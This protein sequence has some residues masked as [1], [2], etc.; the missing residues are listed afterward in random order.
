MASH[1]HYCY[2]WM[3]VKKAVNLK[4][5][6]EGVDTGKLSLY[7]FGAYK[8]LK[9]YGRASLRRPRKKHVNSNLYKALLAY[10]YTPEL[11]VTGVAPHNAGFDIVATENSSAT[12]TN[13]RQ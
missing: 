2:E 12:A 3:L 5:M 9:M 4:W 10:W 8:S 6:Q 1:T 13:K 7:D 11:A